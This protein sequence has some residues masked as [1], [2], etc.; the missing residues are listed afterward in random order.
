LNQQLVQ[1]EC[2]KLALPH[3]STEGKS[4]IILVIARDAN[5]RPI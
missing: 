4:D 2:K 5:R 1:A 3:A